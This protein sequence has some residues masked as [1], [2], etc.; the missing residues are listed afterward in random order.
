MNSS[1]RLAAFGAI[2]L[3]LASGAA[4]SRS[5]DR[6]QPMDIDGGAAEYSVDDNRPTIISGGVTISQGT[7]RIQATRAEITMRGGDPVRAVLTG[8]PVRLS[9]Q[10]DDG[11]PMNA[12]AARVDYDL[13][14]ETVVFTG[15]V[16]ITQPR[17]S[18]SGGRVTYNMRSGQVNTGSPESGGRVKMRILPRAA[19]SR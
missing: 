1:P 17:G 2:A 12:T 18:L 3:L 15:A 14:G 5:S 8:G 9:Q 7:L 11:T 16:N 13:K 19:G 10:L 4:W 6:N